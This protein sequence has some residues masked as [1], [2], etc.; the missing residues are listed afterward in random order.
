MELEDGHQV[1]VAAGSRI[2][3]NICF[4]EWWNNAVLFM[5]L[6]ALAWDASQ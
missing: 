3:A 4:A 1:A 2:D 6:Q 5:W